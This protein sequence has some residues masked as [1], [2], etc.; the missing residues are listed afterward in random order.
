MKIKEILGNLVIVS[1]TD[2]SNTNNLMNNYLLFMGSKMIVGEV[3]KIKETELIVN[4]VGE[5]VNNNFLFG[6]ST[7]PEFN[8]NISLIFS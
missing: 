5:I 6:I 4:L 3:I 1:Y 2:N 8:S 7:K